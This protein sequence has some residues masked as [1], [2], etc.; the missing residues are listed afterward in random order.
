MLLNLVPSGDAQ[1][2]SAFTDKG[3]DIGGGEEDEGN[4]EVLDES[5]VETVLAAELDIGT[6]KEVECG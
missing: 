3:G 5:D 6:L 1:V 4:G 2:D